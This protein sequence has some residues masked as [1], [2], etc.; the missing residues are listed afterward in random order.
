M[1]EQVLWDEH[2]AF[3]DALVEDGFLVLG[4]P[5]SDGRRVLHVVSAENEDAIHARLTEDPWT[6]NGLLTT[7]SVERWTILLD[8]RQVSRA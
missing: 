8:G 6:A 5:L 2:A 1:R 7:T 4:G 3:M